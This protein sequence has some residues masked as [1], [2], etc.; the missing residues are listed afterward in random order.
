MSR[1]TRPDDHFIELIKR[2]G[3]VD[4]NEALVAQHE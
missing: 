1:M 2:S 3:S 4:K